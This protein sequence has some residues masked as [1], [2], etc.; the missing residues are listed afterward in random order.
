VNLI[1]NNFLLK[2]LDIISGVINNIEG[3]VKKIREIIRLHSLALEDILEVAKRIESKIESDKSSFHFSKIKIENIIIEGRINKITMNEFQQI[4]ATYEALK[5]N[6]QPTSVQNPRA[7]SDNEAVLTAELDEANKRT[8][9]KAVQNSVT[10]PT[11]VAVRVIA[12]ADLGE[13]VREIS[14]EGSV[15]VT[16]GEAETLALKFE[17]P[18]DQT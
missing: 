12:D 17:E 10:E 14:I 7:V 2:K 18:V 6:G 15:L 9:F 11:A 5:K 8:T 1:T 4:S 3:I 16:P 13:G